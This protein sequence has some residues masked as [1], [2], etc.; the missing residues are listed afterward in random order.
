MIQ[1]HR[2]VRIL[3][4]YN[5]NVLG[6][7]SV[8]ALNG[9]AVFNQCGYPSDG[10]GSNF[11]AGYDLG[12]SRRVGEDDFSGDTSRTVGEAYLLIGHVLGGAD[13]H[14]GYTFPQTGWGSRL[15]VLAA[16]LSV[17]LNQSLE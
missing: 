12:N 3:Y 4:F 10:G 17:D 11:F 13:T 15:G 9:D 6:Q 7:F 1:N 5:M 2:A 16:V 14:L 8:S